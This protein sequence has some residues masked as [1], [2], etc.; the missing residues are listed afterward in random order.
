MICGIYL[1]YFQVIDGRKVEFDTLFKGFSYFLPSLL[2]LFAIILPTIFIMM[3]V[4]APFI[5]AILMG[6]HLNPDEFLSLII[7]GL[8][9]DL[10]AVVIMVC[11]HTLLMFAF[12]LMVDRKLTAGLAI[13]LR[14]KAVRT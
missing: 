1:C 3:I 8:V 14:M 2:L 10:I 12:P 5:T 9:V 6:Q 11:F 13:K 4:Y 7:G